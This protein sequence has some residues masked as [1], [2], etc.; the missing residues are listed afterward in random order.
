MELSFDNRRILYGVYLKS[1]TGILGRNGCGKTSLLR[2]LFAR[3]RPKYK[4]MRVDGIPQKGNLY[5]TDLAA[6]LPQHQLLPNNL[7]LLDAY[8]YFDVKWKGFT[9]DFYSFAI[10]KKARGNELSSGELRVI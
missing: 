4:N 7:K 2:V 1:E 9:T 10:Y 8:R 3:L 5:G 6:Y